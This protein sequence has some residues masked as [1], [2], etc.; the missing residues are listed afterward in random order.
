M[1]IKT[2]EF[3]TGISLVEIMV[4]LVISI[5]LLGGIIQ[6]YLGNKTTFR[7]ANAVSEVQE[8]GRYSM[9]IMSKDLRHVGDWGCISFDPNNTSNINNTLP[10]GNPLF[11]FLNNPAIAGTDNTGLNNSDT[12]TIRGSTSGQANIVPLFSTIA[13]QF[14]QT[15]A[16]NSI[17]A[18]DVVLITR[19]GTNNLLIPAEADIFQATGNATAGATSTISHNTVL[20]QI[21][22]N[23]AA[24]KELQTVTYSIQNNANGQPS[25]F[26]SVFGNDQ[27][28]IDGV[29]DLQVLYGIDTDIVSDDFPNQYVTIDNVPGLPDTSAVV[30]IRLMLLVSSINDFVTE[31]PQV[32][33]FNGTQTTAPDRRLR[34]VFTTTIALR[35]R[36]GSS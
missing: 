18:N 13:Q 15:T 14:L 1:N 3:Q 31:T 29:D 28:L 16:I 11:D 22:R 8:N 12:L 19:C 32:Y 27:A 35:N 17:A 30:S 10:G 7:F 33:T 25:L 34:Q 6:V 9:D 36:I 5:F 21:Y 4:A 23:D 26:R 24:I 20:S 2:R